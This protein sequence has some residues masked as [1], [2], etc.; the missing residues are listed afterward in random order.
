MPVQGE[1][2]QVKV[3]ASKTD[4]PSHLSVEDRLAGHIPREI[5]KVECIMTHMEAHLLVEE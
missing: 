5:S 2:V 4:T 1:A 3:V